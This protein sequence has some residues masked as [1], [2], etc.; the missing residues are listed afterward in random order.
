MTEGSPWG[1]FI[2]LFVVFGLAHIFYVG[3]VNPEVLRHRVWL[4]KGTETWDWVWLSVFF[5]VM[6]S[7]FVVAHLD[8]LSGSAL[9]PRSVRPVSSK[10]PGY[11][12]YSARVRSRLLPGVW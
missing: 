6:C 8:I 12:A 4:K 11:T 2:G 5:P 9:L 3:L 1:P 10:L 7:I